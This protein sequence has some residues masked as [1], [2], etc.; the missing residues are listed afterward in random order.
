MKFLYNPGARM[1]L[2]LS[3]KGKRQGASVVMLY[4]ETWGIFDVFG[5]RLFISP[6]IHQKQYFHEG[7]Q[8][9]LFGAF[10]LQ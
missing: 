4:Q 2:V 8:K 1:T 3:V 9:P 5:V 10:L 7:E 6:N